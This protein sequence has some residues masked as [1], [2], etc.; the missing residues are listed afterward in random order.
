MLLSAHSIV[1]LP[2]LL[3]PMRLLFSLPWLVLA[4]LVLTPAAALAQLPTLAQAETTAP[5]RPTLQ[6]GSEGNAVIEVQA[7]L[8]LLGFY[9]GTVDGQYSDDT[10]AAVA[11]FQQSAGLTADGVVGPDTWALLL[12]VAEA[13]AAEPAPSA[14]DPADDDLS[15]GSEAGPS[16][17]GDASAEDDSSNLGA[18]SASDESPA[19]AE[20]PAPTAAPEDEESPAAETVPVELP[21]LRVGMEGPAV[22]RL[23]QRLRTLGTYSGSLDGVFGPD[24]ERGVIQVQRNAGIEADGIV[25]PVTWGVL[26]R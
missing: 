18:E 6:P 17:G 14:V 12:P 13:T 8:T 23:Q 19:D 3:S 10:A 26:L 15:D 9:Q 24:T 7:L 5:D 20:A 11:Q 4:P 16:A 21:I 22:V 2:L 25:G 1:I